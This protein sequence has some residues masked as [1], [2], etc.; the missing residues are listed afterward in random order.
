MTPAGA[1]ITEERRVASFTVDVFAYENNANDIIIGVLHYTALMIENLSTPTCRTYKPTLRTDSYY[2]T[3]VKLHYSVFK[4]YNNQLESRFTNG[5]MSDE[6]LE[7]QL[8]QNV[9]P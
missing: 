6:R 1:L 8:V 9:E 5:E 2:T 7:C 3:M 4:E